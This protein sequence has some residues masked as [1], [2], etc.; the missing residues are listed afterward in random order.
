MFKNRYKGK[1]RAEKEIEGIE[2]YIK[3]SKELKTFGEMSGEQLYYKEHFISEE[4]F[5]FLNRFKVREYF[6]IVYKISYSLNYD[7][8]TTANRGSYTKINTRVEF[9]DERFEQE[10]FTNTFA[11]TLRSRKTKLWGRR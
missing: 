1:T 11:N 8:D 3:K 9:S 2:E 4:L 6:S 7:I 10:N 5:D